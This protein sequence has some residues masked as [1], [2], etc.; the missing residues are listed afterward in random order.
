MPA[1]NHQEK[2]YCD[3][4]MMLFWIQKCLKPVHNTKRPALLM[5]DNFSAHLISSVRKELSD[6]GWAQLYLP[7]NMTSRLQVL[8][9]GINKPFKDY[10][11]AHYNRFMIDNINGKVTRELMGRW[12]ANSWESIPCQFIINTSKNIGFRN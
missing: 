9:V 8:D 5:M 6:C 4:D 2:G 1:A 10:M 3:R 7:P 11:K 12:I